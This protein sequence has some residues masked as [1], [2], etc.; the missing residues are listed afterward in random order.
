MRKIL[1][2]Q[3]PLTH[4]L[5]VLE[6]GVTTLIAMETKP[7]SPVRYA[8][9][10]TLGMPNASIKRDALK[11]PLIVTCGAYEATCPR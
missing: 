4:I 2:N 11:H 5:L 1:T 3:N 9:K 10:P 6:V 7:M 8:N